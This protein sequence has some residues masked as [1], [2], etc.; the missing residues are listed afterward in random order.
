MNR[1]QDPKCANFSKF[2]GGC[3]REHPIPEDSILA[4]YRDFMHGSSACG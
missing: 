2:T 1:Q 3:T 4:D